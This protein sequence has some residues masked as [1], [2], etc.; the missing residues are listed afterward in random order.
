MSSLRYAFHDNVCDIQLSVEM[1]LN[2][3]DG[4]L[5]I[6]FTVFKLKW[7]WPYRYPPG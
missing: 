7:Q 2:R 1:G 5:S 6:L 4:R 3:N